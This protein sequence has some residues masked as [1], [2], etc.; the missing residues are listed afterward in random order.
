MKKV[1][2]GLV[3]AGIMANSV[4]YPSLAEFPDVNMVSLCDIV[5]DKLNNTADK[6]GIPNRYSDY[7]EM[8]D[9]E[10]LEAVYIL[11][12]PHQLFD[13]TVY[14]LKKG[15]HVFIEKPP[16][17]T[18]F[19]IKSLERI[20]RKNGCI[21]MVGFNRRYIPMMTYAKDYVEKHGTINQVVA[22]FYKRSSAVYYDGAVDVIGCDAIHAVDA[23]RWMAGSDVADAVCLVGQCEDVVP[24][25]WNAIVRFENG[26][27]GV[28]LTN[29]N[30]GTR[31]HTFEIHAPGVSA[32]L[33]P[34]DKGYLYKD[35]E[36]TTL[37]TREIANS[38]ENYKYYGFFQESRHFIDCIKS[39]EEPSS[40]FRDA[41]KTME[42]VD[43]LRTTVI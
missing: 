3:G 29:W 16:A 40:S 23:L 8:I 31:V 15:L 6:F 33:N 24:N 43:M 2:V 4:H 12:P 30:V 39:G 27:S 36:V 13:I 42:L 7:R 38:S 14:A 10:P 22:T 18:T 19:Q 25:S 34:D 37:D 32:F 21:T 9:K 28:L 20:A 26:V 17:V 11:M 5:E 41:V 35:D 1:N